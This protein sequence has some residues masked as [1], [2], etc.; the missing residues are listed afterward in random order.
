M[1]DAEKIAQHEQKI[2]EQD[3]RLIAMEKNG[4]AFGD[5]VKQNAKDIRRVE[6]QAIDRFEHLV[7][8][9]NEGFNRVENNIRRVETSLKEDLNRVETSLKEDINRVETGL[10]EDINRVETNLKNDI[11]RVEGQ[12][13]K[14]LSLVIAVAVIILGIL[15]YMKG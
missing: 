1:T 14:W 3:R 12:T 9:M 5:R 2:A 15:T 8:L 6:A 13:I 7:N 10:K 11:N 4:V